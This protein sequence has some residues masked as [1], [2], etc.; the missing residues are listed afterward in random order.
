MHQENFAVSAANSGCH[1]G[2]GCVDPFL[3]C[4][5][6]SRSSDY[7]QIDSLSCVELGGRYVLLSLGS[8]S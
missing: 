1:G 4:F 5:F 2:V 3:H 8:A 7:T 6:V